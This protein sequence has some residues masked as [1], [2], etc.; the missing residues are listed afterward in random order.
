VKIG[1]VC[2]PVIGGSG[3]VATELG[4]YLARRG[5]QVHF[6]SYALPFRLDPMLDNLYYH[7]VETSNYPLF[8]YPPYTLTLAAKIAEIA[9]QENLDLI[10]A[11]YAIPH[12]ICGYLAK[13]MLAPKRDLKIITTLHGTDVT[14]VGSEK[15]FKEITKFSMMSSDAVS[16]VSLHLKNEVCKT[17]RLCDEGRMEVIYNFIDPERYHPG[18]PCKLK[19][20]FAPN[21]EKLIMHMSNFRPLKRIPDVIE[22]FRKINHKIKSKL[23]LIGEGPE[24]GT[25]NEMISTYDLAGDVFLMGSRQNVENILSAGDLFLLPSEHE[26]FGLA[27]MEALCSGV[28]VI[29]TWLT[30]LPELITEGKSGFLCD[31]GDT[32]SMAEKSVMLLSDNKMWQEFSDYAH[33]SVGEKFHYEKIVGQYEDLYRKVLNS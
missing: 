15:S 10:H 3:V 32:E 24:I 17:F 1:I 12:A 7:Q 6:F 29:G 26:S 16:A 9:D 30:G 23:V 19:Q 5:H 28:P 20:K 31:I 14:L 4:I 33:K 2:Y 21:G 11:H 22:T 8:K 25:A 27:A 13:Q 18:D